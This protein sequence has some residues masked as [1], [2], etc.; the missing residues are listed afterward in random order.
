MHTL[1]ASGALPQ[2][3]L[4][5]SRQWGTG[6]GPGPG[7]GRAT[8]LALRALSRWR[9]LLSRAHCPIGGTAALGPSRWP[10][11]T[12]TPDRCALPLEPEV[13]VT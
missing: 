1:L 9:A 3:G 2:A 7:A 13:R 10:V 4:G 11:A 8:A 12:R 5:R 6:I